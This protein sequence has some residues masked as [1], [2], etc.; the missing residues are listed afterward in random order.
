MA[1]Q[2]GDGLHNDCRRDEKDEGAFQVEGGLNTLDL[3][4]V[5]ASLTQIE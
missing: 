2:V 3:N 4:G 1:W 5:F